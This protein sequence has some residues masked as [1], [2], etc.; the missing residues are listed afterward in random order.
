[1]MHG[2]RPGIFSLV[3]R[4]SAALF[5]FANIFI[6]VRIISP[7]ELGVWI[8]F[9]SIA[10]FLETIRNGFV[11]NPF[12]SMLVVAEESDGQ[13]L[14]QASLN[15]HVILVIITTVVLVL[16]AAPLNK[17]WNIEQ[18][19]EL[20]YIYAINSFVLIGFLHFEYLLQSKLDFK[21]VFVTNFTRFLI[22]F[23]YISFHYVTA[24]KP[25]LNSLAIVQLL[26]SVVG[27]SVYYYFVKIHFQLSFSFKWDNEIVK[28]LFHL[29][30]YT[31][32]TNISAMLMKNTDSWMIGRLI[33]ASGVAMYNPAIRIANI[34]EVPTLAIANVVF[35]Q[36]GTKLRD[37][38]VSG[39]QSIYTKSVSLILAVMLPVM[40]PIYF[41]ADKIVLFIFGIEYEAAIPILKVTLIYTLFVP[42]GRQ[43]GTIMDGLQRPKLNFYL[44]FLMTILNLIFNYVCIQNYG[45]IGAAYGSL[46]SYGIVFIIHQVILYFTFKINTMNVFIEIFAWYLFGLKYVRS[47]LVY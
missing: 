9:G 14:I 42:F 1:M 4:I 20:L 28:K 22:T 31:F 8:L 47:K 21:A 2:I 6:L 23:L 41:L 45:V 11:R 27:V 18:L 26:S 24:S 43:F 7:A 44:L 19:D 16:V 39:I 30:K 10:G 13:K 36:V 34:V 5:G 32:G 37:Q 35:P 17:F 33:S 25:T 38:G 46:L 29:G 40:V 12:I 3:N 15:L